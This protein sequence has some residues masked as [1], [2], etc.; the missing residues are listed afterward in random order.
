MEMD[1]LVVHLQFYINKNIIYV[2]YKMITIWELAKMASNI[3]NYV[4]T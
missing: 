2:I 3:H 4:G 1:Y